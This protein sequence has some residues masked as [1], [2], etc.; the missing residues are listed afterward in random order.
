MLF[1]LVGVVVGGGFE[2][3]DVGVEV[4]VDF[5][6]VVGV[7]GHPV[8]ERLAGGDL[9]LLQQRDERVV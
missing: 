1:E 7:G 9:A 6:D 3:A 8:R 4:G 5:V 2:D